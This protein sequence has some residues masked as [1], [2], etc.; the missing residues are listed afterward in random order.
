MK[1]IL[2][3][4]MLICAVDLLGACSSVP[5]RPQT[6]ITMQDLV[7]TL[8]P[9]LLVRC[10]SLPVPP[11]VA[12]P[13][14]DLLP[15]YGSLQGQYNNCAIKDDCLIAAITGETICFSPGKDNGQDKS[16]KKQG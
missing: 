5:A 10:E 6:T 14:S 8:D 7:K 16:T 3:V 15:M 9:K 1:K 13:T 4:C 12:T 2:L 11:S